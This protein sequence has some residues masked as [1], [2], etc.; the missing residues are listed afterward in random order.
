MSS[1]FDSSEEDRKY[2]VDYADYKRRYAEYEEKCAVRR[3]RKEDVLR[4]AEAL[5]NKRDQWKA[6]SARYYEH[7]P[8]VKEKKRLKAAEQRAAKKLARRRWDPPRD[9]TRIAKVGRPRSAAARAR[10]R[11]HLGD[12]S[13]HPNINLTPEEPYLRLFPPEFTLSDFEVYG[14]ESLHSKPA[15]S[16][17][18]SSGASSSSELS[19]QRHPIGVVESLLGLGA[20]EPT[21]S[22]LPTGSKQLMV[23][24][25]WASVVLQYES[26]RD[27]RVVFIITWLTPR[28]NVAM[29]IDGGLVCWDRPDTVTAYLYEICSFP[30]I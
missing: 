25:T 14:P 1:D 30:E 29:V 5:Q 23:K 26:R 6:A 4:K 3:K 13:K 22:P 27:F 7:H 28:M 21:Q 2:K 11:E 12:F 18:N 15:K 16:K 19:P 17:P 10:E 9:P 20:G 8:E 24:D